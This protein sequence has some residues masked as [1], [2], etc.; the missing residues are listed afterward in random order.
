MYN[1]IQEAEPSETKKLMIAEVIMMWENVGALKYTR[2]EGR[3]DI[4]LMEQTTERKW[5]LLRR[6]F[7]TLVYNMKA[8]SKIFT[9]F[10]D[11]LKIKFNTKNSSMNCCSVIL[12]M[13]IFFFFRDAFINK[14]NF[15]HILF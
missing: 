5:R 14:Y 11:F 10:F 13:G 6:R 4:S 15:E 7:S 12:Y 1:N 8:E 2:E 3:G 9:R